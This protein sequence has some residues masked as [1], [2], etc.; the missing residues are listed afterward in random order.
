[1]EWINLRNDLL[2]LNVSGVKLRA[3]NIYIYIFFVNIQKRENILAQK[4]PN[5]EE[6]R[7]IMSPAWQHRLTN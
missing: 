3:L 6:Y 1:M 7:T 4:Q 5:K 2:V